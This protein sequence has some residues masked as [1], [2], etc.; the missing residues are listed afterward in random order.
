MKSNKTKSAMTALV[1]AAMICTAA[2]PVKAEESKW[3]NNG[4]NWS[5]IKADGSKATGWVKDGECWYAFDENGSMRT[6]WVASHEHWYYMGESGVMQVNTM[7]EDNGATYFVKSTGVMAKDYVKDGYEFT[8]DGK[9]IPLSESKSVVLT[10]ASE[11]EGKVIEGNLYVDITTAKEIELKGVTV[12][13]KLVIV[14]D[15]ETA[16]KVTLI[17]STIDTVSTQTR[18]TEF[19]LGKDANVD[20]FSM[21]E[22]AEVKS[23]KEFK[24]TIETIEI[25]STT[26][27][28]I[29]IEV[30]T[31]N[32]STNSYAPV[33]IK[34]PVENLEIKTE[35]AIKVD[36]DV[37]NLTVT[38]T[39]TDTK[40]EVKKGSTIGTVMADAPV[41]IDGEGTVEK[42]EANVDGVEASKDT[43]IKK[44]ET[45]DGVKEAPDATKPDKGSSTGGSDDGGSTPTPS[46]DYKVTNEKELETALNSATNGQVVRLENDFS[47]SKQI[48][49]TNKASFTLDGNNKTLT[50]TKSEPTKWESGNAFI[51]EFYNSTK[52]IT[53]KN[54]KLTGSN[55]GMLVNSANVKLEGTIDVSGNGFGGINV[56]KGEEV[57][58]VTIED[59]VLNVKSAKLVN[60]TETKII[61]TIFSEISSNSKVDYINNQLYRSTNGDQY[62]YFINSANAENQPVETTSPAPVAVRRDGP[63]DQAPDASRSHYGGKENFQYSKAYKDAGADITVENGK[64][65]IKLPHVFSKPNETALNEL[66]GDTDLGA[67]TNAL[68]AGVE[69]KIPENATQ[70]KRSND[71]DNL[72]EASAIDGDNSFDGSLMQYIAIGTCQNDEIYTPADSNNYTKYYQFLDENGA[73][74]TTYKLDIV[75]EIVTVPTKAEII[76]EGTDKQFLAADRFLDKQGLI[77]NF[78]PEDYK[79]NSVDIGLQLVHGESK[80]VRV[81]VQFD[82]DNPEY[83]ESI[84]K[85][86]QLIA[87]DSN[88]N[89]WD[90]VQMG[91]GP[92]GGFPIPKE[93][94]I[95]TVYVIGKA[96]KYSGNIYLVENGSIIYNYG[97]ASFTIEIVESIP[98]KLQEEVVE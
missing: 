4:G 93:E 26:K 16:G 85:N 81:V 72:G 41:K 51:L 61:P 84:R 78:K 30:P 64:V 53:V 82:G 27:G 62:Y 70:V 76:I 60:T 34:A 89:A 20:K 57:P 67:E 63:N 3:V 37:K 48:N 38:E 18:N 65:T 79:N 11:L 23:T 56:D 66:Y 90:I 91:W 80:N 98:E 12:K 40:L 45:G 94:Q 31:K 42:V 14:G 86:I 35:T 7:V 96:G 88:N 28:T 75:I 47:V 5:L 6:G 24:G 39:A 50:S 19:V 68:Y 49:V 87:I 36:A 58:G 69:I 52:Q 25:Q 21:E 95:T 71:L 83:S 74:I 10:D 8:S 32:V 33:E 54:I 17:D 59:A 43:T 46:V 44:V 77:Q 73:V 92:E 55:A 97:S 15:N 2:M 13:G 9:A 1:I 22:L 29:V